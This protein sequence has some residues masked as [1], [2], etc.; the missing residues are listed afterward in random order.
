MILFAALRG[1]TV[2]IDYPMYQAYFEQMH[3][4][5]WQFLTGPENEYR[6]EFGF[7]LLNYVVSRFT[8]D[9]HVFMAVAAAILVGLEAI[10]LYR[11]CAIP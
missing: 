9:V 6:I 8:G 5:G 2:G 1:E 3:R 7:S 10:V 11:D 4:G